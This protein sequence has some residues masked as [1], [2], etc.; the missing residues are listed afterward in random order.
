MR[1][2]ILHL[3][4]SK[5]PFPKLSLSPFLPFFL[6]ILLLA[7]A[8]FQPA[9]AQVDQL[10][11]SRYGQAAYYNYSEEADVTILV[12]A[13][14]AVQNPGLYEVPRGMRL[15]RLL[16]ITGGPTIGTQRR[17]QEQRLTLALSRRM[18]GGDGRRIIFE[19][20]ME[21]DVF[22]FEDDPILQDGDVL[23]AERYVRDRFTW[24][25]FIPIVGAAASVASTILTITIIAG[26]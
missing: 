1:S 7:F 15:S 4:S 5:A 11:R 18:P 26:E 24:R 10:Q 22:V 21:D 17:G 16:S 14:G 2:S 25:D 13:W 12:S 8:A 3:P 23:T 9:R 6:S 19:A 20:T